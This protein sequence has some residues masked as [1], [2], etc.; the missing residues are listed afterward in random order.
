MVRPKI[1]QF[2]LSLRLA[3]AGRSAVRFVAVCLLALASCRDASEAPKRVS[4][5][6][7]AGFT[8]WVREIRPDAESSLGIVLLCEGGG[9]QAICRKIEQLGKACDVL[10]V[11]DPTIL[12]ALMPDS[13]RWRIDFSGDE[14]VLGVGIRAPRVDDAEEDWIPV[15]LDQRVALARAREDMGPLGYRTLMVWQLAD[16]GTLRL[17]ERLVAKTA[18]E[19]DDASALAALLKSGNADY[20][21]L[22]RS[23]CVANDLRYIPLS[24]AIN[25]GT[26]GHDYSVT[27][28]EFPKSA[29]GSGG[30]RIRVTGA[31][32]VFSLTIPATSERKEAAIAC[33]RFFL[34]ERGVDSLRKNGFRPIPP[35]FF[36]SDEDY[37]PFRD[38]AEK[39][40]EYR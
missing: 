7:A 38:I 24:D 14:M 29:G 26:S 21:F 2:Q 9:S 11:A 28:V 25:L 13:V 3:R 27:S 31:P 15:L 6:H 17:R 10:M 8:A 35:V 30:E 36:G 39:A 4:L 12:P 23:S 37:E 20:A 5:F 1:E 19:V 34:G 33:V 40:G 16:S 22:Y 18:R 32:I